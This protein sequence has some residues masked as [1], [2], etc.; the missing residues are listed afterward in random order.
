[1]QVPNVDTKIRN[2]KHEINAVNLR[3]LR[4]VVRK[5]TMTQTFL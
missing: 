2:P 1:M 4:S 5:F 3:I